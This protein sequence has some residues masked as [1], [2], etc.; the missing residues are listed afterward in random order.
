MDI[1][2]K[3]KKYYLTFIFGNILADRNIIITTMVLVYY[4]VILC[5]AEKCVKY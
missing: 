1:K 5:K 4:L 2:V 3:N